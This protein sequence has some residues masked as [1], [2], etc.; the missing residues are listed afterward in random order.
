MVS[1]YKHAQATRAT[2]RAQAIDAGLVVGV[3]DHGSGGADPARGA[4][5]RGLRDY[6]TISLRRR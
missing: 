2:V 1:V 5:L 6:R 3:S 4:G